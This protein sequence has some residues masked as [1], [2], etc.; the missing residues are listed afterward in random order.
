VRGI[1]YKCANCVDY[2]LCSNCESLS[3]HYPTHTFIKIRIPIPPH[4]NP[5]SMMFPT[6]Y[7]GNLWTKTESFNTGQLERETHCMLDSC[8]R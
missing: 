4:A 8:S 5:R 7:P 2:D 3:V 6:L 1:R